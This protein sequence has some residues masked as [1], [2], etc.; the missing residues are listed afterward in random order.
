MSVRVRC[1]VFLLGIAVSSAG[2]GGAQNP[3]SSQPQQQPNPDAQHCSALL[4][5]DFE[6]VAGLSARVTT[7]R[8]IDVPQSP[9]NAAPG[10][11]ALLLAKSSIKRYCAVTGY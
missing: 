9:A 3:A 11:P 6:S 2:R 7:A 4:R 5:L 1:F 8:M 10:S